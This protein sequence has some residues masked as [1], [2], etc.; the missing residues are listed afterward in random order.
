MNI[1]EFRTYRTKGLRRSCNFGCIANNPKMGTGFKALKKIVEENIPSS[2]HS[3][4][5]KEILHIERY[6]DYNDVRIKAFVNTYTTGRADDC[7]EPDVHGL[8]LVEI[9]QENEIYNDEYSSIVIK[10]FDES[11]FYKSKMKKIVQK[12]KDYPICL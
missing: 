10:R 4:T 1:I 2:K 9:G 6:E 7:E 12:K 8:Y 3:V 5:R 11:V